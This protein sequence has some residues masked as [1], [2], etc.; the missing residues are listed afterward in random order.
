MKL[1]EVE[2][3]KIN[4][5]ENITMEPIITTNI[6]Q[7]IRSMHANEFDLDE[8]N[9][10]SERFT[11]FFETYLEINSD[12]NSSS[13]NNLLNHWNSWKIKIE[14]LANDKR[15]RKKDKRLKL[16]EMALNK[17]II[18]RDNLQKAKSELE[19]GIN[20]L[21][22][23]GCRTLLDKISHIQNKA[24][25]NN[26]S[27]IVPTP[28]PSVQRRTIDIANG[29]IINYKALYELV[30]K[31]RDMLKLKQLENNQ[32]SFQESS[33]QTHIK[34]S[35]QLEPLNSQNVTPQRNI[36][37][38]TNTSPNS[39]QLHQTQHQMLRMVENSGEPQILYEDTQN[40]QS[41]WNNTL[42]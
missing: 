15:T 14:N 12:M 5:P 33:N 32:Y 24:N 27:Q 4:A 19:N 9:N 42:I 34:T 13:V 30:V 35:T 2:K 6:I 40:R 41:I 16:M 23:D 20:T 28:P 21:N 8:F 36:I 29:D 38:S 39:V 17:C 10:F 11:K 31:E 26:H 25:C 37:S 3:N 18:E 1:K 7:E 22:V